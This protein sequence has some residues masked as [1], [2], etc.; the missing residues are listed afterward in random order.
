M[1][2]GLDFVDEL[3][4]GV[5]SVGA[6]D[7]QAT[8]GTAYGQTAA[9]LLIIPQLFA[10]FVE[11]PLFVL[12]DRYPRKWFVCGGLVGMAATAFVCA[13][14][15]SPWVLTASL[16]I[17]YVANGIAINLA[18]ATLMDSHPDHREQLMT[19]WALM[20]MLGALAAPLLMAGV[21]ELS[22][23]WRAAYVVV[24]CI[25]GLYAV[26]L[27]PMRFPSQAPDVAVNEED[28]NDDD[29]PGVLASLRVAVGNTRLMVWLFAA[30]L[31]N[32]LDDILIMFAALH[33]RDN[34][35]VASTARAVILGCFMV[36]G[37][38]GLLATDVAL[39]RIAPRRLLAISAALCTLAYLA[40]LSTAHPWLSGGLFAL[41]GLTCAPLYPI[42]IAQAYRLLPAQSGLVNG[43][44][45]AFTPLSIAL[46]YVL[47]WIADT[48]GLVAAM[49]ILVAQPVG[50][51]VIAL[52]VPAASA[53]ET[54][55]EPA[56]KSGQ[57]P[58]Q[59]P[60]QNTDKTDKD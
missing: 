29:G 53:P 2:L 4:A 5:P 6:P 9:F 25:M 7:I 21:A 17:A 49:F 41:V 58:G 16:S 20:G 23:S 27:A 48:S 37:T 38:V 28:K 30:W 33:L 31:C 10:L 11:P 35:A 15:P 51:F 50:L 3:S 18:Q 1:L 60:A 39:R 34:M 46:P 26:V 24:G 36:G 19:R 32:L 56:Q 59:K 57:K 8:F 12:A 44:S 22:Y 54:A 45:H 43:A 47:G 55:Q 42:A 13:L 52:T 14:A 40:W